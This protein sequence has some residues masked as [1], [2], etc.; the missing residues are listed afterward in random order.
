MASPPSRKSLRRQR[1]SL[2]S[3][4]CGHS[5]R[6]DGRRK[7]FLFQGGGRDLFRFFLHLELALLASLRILM[8]NRYGA[9]CRLPSSGAMAH[10][11]F[12]F[13]WDSTAFLLS[14]IEFF[15]DSTTLLLVLSQKCCTV[16]KLRDSAALLLH[17][18]MGKYMITS[19]ETDEFGG[20]WGEAPKIGTV[21]RFC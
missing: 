3:L 8:R 11:L 9:I 6:Q 5:S 4:W 12:L 21:Q 17:L 19:P 16:T 7:T 1:G 18:F 14:R 20:R 13:F 15:V 2:A 10:H